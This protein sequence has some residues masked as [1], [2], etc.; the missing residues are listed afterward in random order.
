MASSMLTGIF[1][2][3]GVGAIVLVLGLLWVGRQIH[4]EEQDESENGQGKM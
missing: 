3:L 1:C 2:T 4:E